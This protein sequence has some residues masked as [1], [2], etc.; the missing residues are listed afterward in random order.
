MSS[1]GPVA[2][3]VLG[4]DP[5]VILDI[6]E[7]ANNGSL[8]FII[9][10]PEGSDP[11]DID[12]IFFDLTTDSAVQ[13]LEVFPF[14]DTAQVTGFENAPDSVDTLSNGAQ[15]NESYDVGVQFGTSPGSTSGEYTDVG[16]TI[17][18]DDGTPLTVDDLDL[19]SIAVVA[20]SD[21]G[22]G[23]ALLPQDGAGS[24]QKADFEDLESGDTVSTQIGGVT[25]TAQRACDSW[26]S[27][28]DAMVFDT[29]NPTGG[30]HD[31]AYADRGN[32]LIISEDNDASDPDDNYKGGTFEFAFDEPSFVASL[33]VLD[34]E[35]N[36]SYVYA[37]DADWN[38]LGYQQIPYTG[39]NGAAEME[40]GFENVSYL[41]VDIE[42]SGAIDDLCFTPPGG[43][44]QYLLD[45]CTEEPQILLEEDF[46]NIHDPDDSSAIDSDAGWDVEHDQLVTNGCND[47]RLV[48]DKLATDQ[49]VELTF[50]IAAKDASYFEESGCWA[51]TLRVEVN[52]DGEGWILLDE[53]RV[54]EDTNTFIGSETGQ[55]FS[56]DM[57]TLVYSGGVLEGVDHSVQFRFDSDITAS[58]EELIIDNVSVTTD[59][60][61]AIPTV[62]DDA[63]YGDTDDVEDDLSDCGYH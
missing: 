6:Y 43:E 48:F 60:N 28:N 33:T 24:P 44:C 19:D 39:D 10:Q 46:N 15:V 17:F 26:S 53:F 42:G 16:F 27:E 20:D 3:V 4:C 37:Y 9:T 22:Q 45:P 31:L 50:D 21:T 58:N 7:D 12:G 40:L 38:F 49:P 30:D 62:E 18:T 25:I 57:T 2:S 34:I 41:Y 52:V 23:V 59:P 8:V 29:S 47:G 51:D 56:E 1:T 32:V 55:T 54:D 61:C 36:C 14:V 35:N 63:F 13:T 5:E 11:V